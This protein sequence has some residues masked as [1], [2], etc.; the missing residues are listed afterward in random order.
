M[1]ITLVYDP[2]KDLIW[3]RGRFDPP[4]AGDVL[5]VIRPG[6]GGFGMTFDELKQVRAIETDPLTHEV[7]EIMPVEAIPMPT[8]PF[9]EYLRKKP[10]KS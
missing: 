9:P 1:L 4:A 6:E 7:I 3:A 2:E 8:Q 10:A 5:S